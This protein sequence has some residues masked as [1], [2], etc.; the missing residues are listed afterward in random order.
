[1]GDDGCALDATW[2]LWGLCSGNGVICSIE[3]CTRVV[4]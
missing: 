4:V 2:W 1:M 3:F